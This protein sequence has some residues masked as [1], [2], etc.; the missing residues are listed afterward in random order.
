MQTN[1]IEVQEVKL[2]EKVLLLPSP[3]ECIH[4]LN[5]VPMTFHL[6]KTKITHYMLEY[7]PKWIQEK[8][9]YLI[10]ERVWGIREKVRLYI[11]ETGTEFYME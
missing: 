2:L 3:I 7:N 10:S 5:C 1:S 9:Y 11:D 8:K 6:D 4:P